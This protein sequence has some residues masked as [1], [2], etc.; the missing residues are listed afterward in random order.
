MRQNR[1]GAALVAATL[2]LVF[3]AAGC[4]SDTAPSARSSGQ[5]TSAS[6]APGTGDLDH[7]RGPERPS[8]PARTG[9][10]RA[11]ASLVQAMSQGT[12]SPGAIDA[13]FGPGTFRLWQPRH[14]RN[15]FD[16]DTV[17]QRRMPPCGKAGLWSHWSADE[18]LRDFHS[19]L[20]LRA[21]GSLVA[22]QLGVSPLRPSRTGGW[23]NSQ[24]RAL[25]ARRYAP[26]A[27]TS[28]SR[29]RTSSPTSCHGHT[30]ASLSMRPWARATTTASPVVF[31]AESAPSPSGPGTPCC[32]PASGTQRTD[33]RT[34]RSTPTRRSS[35]SVDPSSDNLAAT[36]TEQSRVGPAGQGCQVPKQ[37]LRSP[38]IHRRQRPLA[39]SNGAA[40][41][42]KSA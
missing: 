33:G 25:D 35:T 34:S 29:V 32:S 19:R 26:P 28:R 10:L 31:G 37:L 9:P 38:T 36:T 24:T 39:T 23:G 40:I 6:P 8:T 16:L 5:P 21:D 4:T 3:S 20:T 27:A 42:R 7:G 2:A 18:Q 1:K 30:T 17:F 14:A 11:P 13:T 12:H 22:T 15:K 41:P